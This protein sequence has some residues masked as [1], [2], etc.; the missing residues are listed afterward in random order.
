M[1]SKQL[2]R[3]IQ[4]VSPEAYEY[5]KNLI[6]K[7]FII[8]SLTELPIEKLKE[9]VSFKVINPFD[10]QI[11]MSFEESKHRNILANQRVIELTMQINI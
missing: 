1:E 9:L 10:K 5:Y 6:E 2:F 8:N 4:K 3:I 7:E 11:P